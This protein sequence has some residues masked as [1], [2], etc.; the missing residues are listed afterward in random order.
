MGVQLGYL[1]SEVQLGLRRGGWMNWAAI[2]TVTVL[3]F[4]FGLSWQVAWQLEGLVNQFG[5][6]LEVSVYLEADWSAKPLVAKVEDL[7]GVVEVE[8]IAK[9]EAWMGL[10][11]ELG[12]NSPNSATEILPINPLVDE[13][14]VKARSPEAL[15]ALV[16]QLEQ[17]SGVNEVIYGE[18]AL[19]ILSTINRGLRVL[20]LGVT[21]VLMVSAIA[22]MTT[23]IE[24]IVVSRRREIEIM[25]LVGA[26][27]WW[28]RLPFMMQGVILGGVGGAIAWSIV[29]GFEQISLKLFTQELSVI[30]LLSHFQDSYWDLYTDTT[31]LFFLLL[32]FGALVGGLGGWLGLRRVC[33]D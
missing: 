12:L 9:E 10:L 33:C 14:R 18:A 2:S 31:T 19:D 27:R 21:M 13:L 8:A 28:I 25:H 15:R 22:V 24:L 20:S 1:W 17:F 3:L 7:P 32:V 29:Q 26:S 11:T 23:T 6:Q 30:P 16:P 5:S 4:L